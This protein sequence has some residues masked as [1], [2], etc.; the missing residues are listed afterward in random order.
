[1][2]YSTRSISLAWRVLKS[3]IDE[4]TPLI[5][6]TGVVPSTLMERLMGFTLSAGSGSFWKRLSAVDEAFTSAA[7]G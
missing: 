1:M 2:E 3:S 7:E 6:I 4:G 5:R